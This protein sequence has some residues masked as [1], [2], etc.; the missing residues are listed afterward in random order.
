MA[1]PR[2]ITYG[3]I[4]LYIF[5]LLVV[6]AKLFFEKPFTAWW[7]GLFAKETLSNETVRIAY[8]EPLV[9][10]S[11]DTNDIGSR[12]R[13]LHIYEGLVSIDADLN[14]QPALAVSYGSLDPLTWEFRLRPDVIFHDD[15]RVVMDDVVASLERGRDPNSAL[16][17]LTST[18]SKVEAIDGDTLHISTESPDP[19]L[20][21]KLSYVFITP[22]EVDETKII[23][24]GPY[25]FGKQEEQTLE[26]LR[27]EKYWGQKPYFQKARLETIASKDEKRTALKD[28]AHQIIANIPADI[29]ENFGAK[30]YQM[31]AL[32]SLETNF[33]LFNMS[34]L[35][36]DPGL[37]EAV[38]L[39]LSRQ[40]LSQLGHGFATPATQFVSNG[41]FG[42]D[43]TIAFPELNIERAKELVAIY[44]EAHPEDELLSEL[45]IPTGLE[46]L[47]NAVAKNLAQLGITLTVKAFP[48]GELASQITAGNS[49][50][51]FFGWRSDL[52]DAAD[53]LT[54]VVHS[55]QGSFGQFN[56]TN[57]HNEAVDSLIETSQS[58][59][60]AAD[61]LKLLRSVMH[62]ITLE[63]R[64][65]IPLFSPDLLYA[66][67]PNLEWKPRVDG[68]VLAQEAKK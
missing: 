43:P 54:A 57:Y 51:F 24:T 64:I 36:A 30:A 38:T 27:F 50:F 61:R 31:V 48:P 10:L 68:Y 67:H 12:A 15:Q 55:R 65:G 58:T 33:L 52:G 44:Q 6:S 14:I 37:R 56:G 62:T 13:L 39:T 47:G 7:S 35:F 40:R 2:T 34:G 25:V 59:I 45:N 21:Q 9:S 46:T 5:L 60:K 11:P 41:I 29:A 49:P 17:D 4:A 22:Q 66:M 63:D 19:L 26:V 28:G 18:I 3:G 23:G 32:P 8:A 53:F 16:K 20:L 1:L 42:F